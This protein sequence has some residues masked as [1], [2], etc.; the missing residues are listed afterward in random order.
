VGVW[1]GGW[2]VTPVCEG[3]KRRSHDCLGTDED[4]CL[5]E[6]LIIGTIEDCILVVRG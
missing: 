2:W 6:E 5:S 3:P 1:S 4:G